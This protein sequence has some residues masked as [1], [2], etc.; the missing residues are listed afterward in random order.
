MSYPDRGILT[1]DAQ[2]LLALISLTSSYLVGALPVPLSSAAGFTP[3]KTDDKTGTTVPVTATAPTPN[4]MP[5]LT[6]LTAWVE[7]RAQSQFA[8]RDSVRVAA[9][10]VGDVLK[11]TTTTTNTTTAR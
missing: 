6:E 11:G 8:R 10:A 2:T 1:P 4:A 9:K 3:P 7:A 5:T